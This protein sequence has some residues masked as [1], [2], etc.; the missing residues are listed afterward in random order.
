MLSWLLC[1]GPATAVSRRE[2]YFTLGSLLCGFVLAPVL[3]W[4]AGHLVL[5]RMPMGA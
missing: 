2:L 5:A 3:I 1:P 4:A